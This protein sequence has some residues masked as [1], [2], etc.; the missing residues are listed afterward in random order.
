[1][2]KYLSILWKEHKM[3][4]IITSCVILLQM[5]VGVIFAEEPLVCCFV[6]EHVNVPLY[7]RLMQDA[8]KVLCE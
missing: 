6:G 8:A 3:L 2:K 5:V 1:M 7:E 4:L